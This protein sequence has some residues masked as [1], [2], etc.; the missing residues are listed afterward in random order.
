MNSQISILSLNVG[1]SSSLA[2]LKVLL[3]NNLGFFR[4]FGMDSSPGGLKTLIG[5]CAGDKEISMS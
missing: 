5:G 3:L 1:M 2:G 4:S